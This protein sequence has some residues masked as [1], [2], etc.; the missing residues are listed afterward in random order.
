MR[1]HT[2]PTALHE[3]MQGG[4]AISEMSVCLSVKRVN[5]DKTKETYAHIFM[6]D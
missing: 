4:L 5:C 2:S 3:S 1:K 6:K